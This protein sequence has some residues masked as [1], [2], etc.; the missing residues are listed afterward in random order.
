MNETHIIPIPC[1]DGYAVS[2]DGAIWSERKMRGRGANRVTYKS[3]QWRRLP[4]GPDVHGYRII[5]V[6]PSIS[7]NG[8][9]QKM[10]VHILVC[11]AFH[12]PCPEGME[13]RH[14][15][16]DRGDCRASNLAWGTR[17][18]NQMDRVEHG[19]SNR[20]ETHPMAKLT[21]EEVDE[22]ARLLAEGVRNCSLAARYHVSPSTICCIK[23]GR[24]RLCG[25]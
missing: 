13:C 4:A 6:P 21:N 11:Q 23:K 17:S 1:L 24:R 12:G 5:R 20:G 22:I 16:G 19:T 18:E 9:S 14:L 15:N 3:G 2:E 25:S 10:Y 8:K 7:K